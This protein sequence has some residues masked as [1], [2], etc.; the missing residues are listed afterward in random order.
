MGQ[1][2]CCKLRS[3]EV[4]I[5]EVDIKT[6]DSSQKSTLKHLRKRK[7]ALKSSKSIDSR[8]TSVSQDTYSPDIKK[9]KFTKIRFSQDL[10]LNYAVFNNQS[11]LTLSSM[12]YD[13]PNLLSLRLKECKLGYKGLRVLFESL[14]RF[15]NLRVLDLSGN[16]IDDRSVLFMN[17]I[18]PLL[19]H[20]EILLYSRN[21]I[22][23][24]GMN[25]FSKVFR[26]MLS[27]K[28]LHIDSNYITDDSIYIL[29]KQARMMKLL[30]E[31]NVSNNNLT[32]KSIQ[33]ICTAFR[34]VSN[35]KLIA[36]NNLVFIEDQSS[37]VSDNCG[38]NLVF[39][40]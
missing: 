12:L 15:R 13:F 35:F 11:L 39:I 8:R 17:D 28:I 10:A 36:E 20:L 40:D 38:V 9:S 1:G 22:G 18:L 16:C 32:E 3:S 19:I 4:N 30:T 7:R 31:L 34:E 25:M 33:A 14:E 6:S 2:C 26:Y 37:L 29:S 23:N 27:L 24:I 5:K 21:Y